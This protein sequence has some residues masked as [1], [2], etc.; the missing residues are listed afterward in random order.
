MPNDADGGTPMRAIRRVILIAA[1]L[2][3][4]PVL[5]PAPASVAQ[6]SSP[7]YSRE[8][9]DTCFACHDDQATLAIFRTR[10]AVPSDSNGPFG[11]GQLQCEA[12]H[13]PSGDHSR[14]LRRNEERPPSLD[15]GSEASTPIDVQNGL[16]LDC[17]RADTG[18]GWHGNAHDDNEVACA[19]C[20]SSH[21]ARDPVMT[22]ALQP[23]VCFT[24]HA[25]QR[26]D[27]LKAYAHPVRQAE[28][29]CG[30][31]HSTHGDTAEG[32][33]ARPNVNDTCYQ[34]HAEKRGPLLWEH[35]PVVEDCGSC[36]D[37]HG[38]NHPGMVTL[39]TPML[40]QGCHSQAGHPSLANDADGLAGV[41]PSQYLLDRNCMSCH[42]EVHGSNHPSGSKL[43]R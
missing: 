5:L 30:S 17:H 36:H 29:A 12:C 16:C 24:C 2:G 28:M 18:V 14:R 3:I 8:G 31:C 33:L 4:V 11:H 9:A 34:C 35:A 37:P 26:L 22:M 21:A 43:M 27:T 6:E 23:D 38:S 41:N 10:H 32:H 20:H 15:F 19:D 42:T 25:D 40:C 1:C 13:G 39:R 7:A